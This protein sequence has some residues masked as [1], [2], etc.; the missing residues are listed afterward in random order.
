ML[1]QKIFVYNGKPSLLLICFADNFCKTSS[2]EITNNQRASTQDAFFYSI[3]NQ[4]QDCLFLLLSFRMNN[5]AINSSCFPVNILIHY[6]SYFPS[7][8]LFLWS[9]FLICRD[10]CMHSITQQFYLFY[11]RLYR[12]IILN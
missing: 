9:Y 6:T 4:S 2:V 11:G 10:S 3:W 7:D 12:Q 1:T 8:Y 5:Y